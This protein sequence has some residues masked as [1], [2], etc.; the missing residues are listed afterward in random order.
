MKWAAIILAG[1]ALA[2]CGGS[3]NGTAC[4]QGQTIVCGEDTGTNAEGETCVAIREGEFAGQ[5]FCG[6]KVSGNG[7]R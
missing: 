7:E 2:A 6:P 1:L 5:G 3:G 4:V